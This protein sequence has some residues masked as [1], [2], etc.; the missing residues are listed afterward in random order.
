M[1]IMLSGNSF[2]DNRTRLSV[3]L[4]L[5]RG[6]GISLA[7]SNRDLSGQGAF[8]RGIEDARLGFSYWPTV[9]P[10]MSLGINANFIVPTG[11]RKQE[12][13]YDAVTD[14]M[15]TLPSFSL[16]QTAGEIYSGLTWSL[17]PSAEVNGFIGY[18]CTSDKTEQAF[19]WGL[20][21]LIAPFGPRYAMELGYGQSLTRTGV[22]PNTETLSAALAIKVG[23]GF[24]IVPGVWSDLEAEPIYGGSLGLRFTA[25]VAIRTPKES[26][27]QAAAKPE[28]EPLGGTVLV[29]TPLSN[30]IL[31]DGVELW[32]S[33]QQ[34]VNQTFAQVIP[35]T[36]LDVP[37]LPFSD[38][39]AETIMRSV[40]ALAQAH[41]EADWLLFARVE[42][43][44]V[45]RRSGMRIPLLLNQSNWSAE[46]RMR[47]QLVN[48]RDQH[49]RYSEII[50][51]QAMRR[52]KP[53]L[54]GSDQEVL[55]I[56][57]SR[58]LTFEAYR[59]AGRIIA[60]ELSYAP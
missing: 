13:Y 7:G 52:E 23:R 55:S 19:R 12:T 50:S 22:F 47:V 53:L 14:S 43:E 5:G 6:L 17:G 46:C 32:Q 42:R 48:L 39:N 4:G 41:P 60:R 49:V 28:A 57:E 2:T 24:S 20:G 35:L 3:G 33:I 59:E 29:A 11:F 51:A 54:S 34:E 26:H 15:R 8:Q 37:G 27:I 30:I 10:Q 36:T 44:D 18:F 45:S 38:Q 56:S 58:N 9:M 1:G 16:K 31:A 25:P 40:R 21:A